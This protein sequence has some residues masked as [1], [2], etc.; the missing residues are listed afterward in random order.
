[1]PAGL[2]S[3][4]HCGSGPREGRT[5]RIN[6]ERYLRTLTFWLRPAFA[7]RVANRFQRIVGFDR[8][9]ALSSSAL[10]A[11]IPAAILCGLVLSSIGAK[12]VADHIID[13]YDLTGGGAESVMLVLSQP[14]EAGLGVFGVLF[15]VISMLSFTRA[16]Q[17]LFEQTWELK[18]LSVRNTPNGLRW[19]LVL[20]AYLAVTILI[21]AVVGRGRLEL[22]ASLLTA[23]L[24]GAFLVWGGWILSAKRIAWRDLVPFGV[25][26]AVLMT[27]YSIGLTVLLPHLFSS[28]ATR[29]GVVGAVFATLTAL[30]CAM[31]VIVGSAAAGRE[32][33]D[34]LNRIARGERPPDDEIRRQWDDLVGQMRSR[35]LV[36]RETIPHRHRPKGPTRP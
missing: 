20:V 3:R 32:V 24:T 1:M 12:D 15:L 6:R 9:M 10:T 21:H 16:V 28:Y 4:C 25:I 31:V 2:R 11:M 8:S 30:F 29:Y 7:L 14:S 23:P 19:A 13:R 5:A 26:A 18:P 27:V 22:A 34:E 33:R 36:A 17:R 35:W